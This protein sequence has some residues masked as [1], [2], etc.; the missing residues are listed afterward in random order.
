MLSAKNPW[1]NPSSIAQQPNSEG[2][3]AQQQCTARMRLFAGRCTCQLQKSVRKGC[4][5]QSIKSVH[6]V[7]VEKQRQGRQQ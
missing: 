2:D 7:G 3:G 4:T 6:L 5:S 1:S